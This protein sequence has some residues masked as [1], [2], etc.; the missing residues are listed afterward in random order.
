[1]LCN[2]P[3]Y[4]D[5]PYC[6]AHCQRQ[7][8]PKLMAAAAC[9]VCLAF[10]WTPPKSPQQREPPKKSQQCPLRIPSTVP[11]TTIEHPQNQVWAMGVIYNV[12]AQADEADK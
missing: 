7:P 8:F 2:L 5:P 11:W 3:K 6:G 1:M 4:D 9:V 12:H 10:S